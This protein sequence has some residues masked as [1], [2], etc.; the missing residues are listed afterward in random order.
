MEVIPSQAAAGGKR[1]GQHDTDLVDGK[2]LEN[3]IDQ[4]GTRNTEGGRELEGERV[5][6]R[7]ESLIND[8]QRRRS[9]HHGHQ[10]VLWSGDKFPRLLGTG[11]TTVVGCWVM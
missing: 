9:G 7:R 6:E 2:N 10:F 5:G 11:A 3:E 8:C 1:G 4:R